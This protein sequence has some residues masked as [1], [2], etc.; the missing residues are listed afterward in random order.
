MK[1]YSFQGYAHSRDEEL[2]ETVLGTLGGLGRMGMGGLKKGAGY[3]AR[4]GAS[5]ASD[6]AG[7]EELRTSRSG[8]ETRGSEDIN[9]GAS[10]A[11]DEAMDTVYRAGRGIK[12]GAGIAARGLSRLAGGAV[13]RASQGADKLGQKM[14]STYGQPPM[15]Q[16]APTPPMAKPMMARDLSKF[17]D[18]LKAGGDADQELA[19]RIEGPFGVWLR[20]QDKLNTPAKTTKRKAKTTE[21]EPMIPIN[22]PARS[23]KR[24]G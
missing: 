2:N 19:G 21:A 8:L 16:V 6:K 7:R 18:Q 17:I 5:I 20:K 13:R 14:G 9:Q 11:G 23:R 10:R 3:L 24:V 15:A 1:N 4:L 22:K 12:A